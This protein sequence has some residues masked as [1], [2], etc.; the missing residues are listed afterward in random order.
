MILVPF[1]PSMMG[2]YDV[3]PPAAYDPEEG[4]RPRTTNTKPKTDDDIFNEI[5]T[6]Y[7][8]NPDHNIGEIPDVI[9]NDPNLDQNWYHNKR[10]GDFRGVNHQA[11]LFGDV[12]QATDF[13]KD[14][15]YNRKL[16]T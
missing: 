1:D 12:P 13:M 8:T 2:M 16:R 11:K 9:D 15:E 10:F 3:P 6:F 7:K 14:F 5:M 4:E